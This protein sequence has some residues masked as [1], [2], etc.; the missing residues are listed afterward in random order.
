MLKPSDGVA[1]LDAAAGLRCDGTALLVEAMVVCCG[2]VILV[3]GGQIMGGNKK[4]IN[5]KELTKRLIKL[6]GRFLAGSSVVD[7]Y[8][9]TPKSRGLCD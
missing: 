3:N 4:F 1:P 7:L 5:W 2:W 9:V 6:W 8:R